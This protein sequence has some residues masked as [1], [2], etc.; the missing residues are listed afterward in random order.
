MKLNQLKVDEI[1]EIYIKIYENACELL[2][3]AELLFDFTKYSRAYLCAHIS[4]EE[5]GKLPMLYTTALNVH[6]GVK[7]DWKDL[8]KRLRD[9]KTKTS[10]SYA[11]NMM[12]LNV[13]KKKYDV[14]DLQGEN[15]GIVLTQR[16]LQGFKDFLDNDFSL[17]AEDLFDLFGNADFKNE[18]ILRQ[19]LTEF[20][21][22]YKNLSLYADFKNEKF[23]KPSEVID[24]NRCIRRIMV[25]LFQ[26]K[27]LD[28]TDAR[29]GF[30]LFNFDEENAFAEL[31]SII[32][33]RIYSE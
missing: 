21:N 24:E 32:I 26:K 22:G 29:N 9:H 15:S 14:T 3:E 10:L 20:L 17:K 19:G 28:I 13:L 8:N 6:N 27:L 31:K 18:Y 2:E 12:M 4:V 5:F 1:K 11:I 7:V 16:D 23:V 33:Q 25:A 30:N